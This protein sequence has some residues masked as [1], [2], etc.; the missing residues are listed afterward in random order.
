MQQMIMSFVE[1]VR[2]AVMSGFFVYAVLF[3]MLALTTLGALGNWR[4]IAAYMLGWM[5]AIFAVVLITSSLGGN[6]ASGTGALVQQHDALNP[7]VLIVPAIFGGAAGFGLLYVLIRFG[8]TEGTRSMIIAV[9]T[10]LAGTMVFRMSLAVGE[11]RSVISTGT[12]A[13]AIGALAHIVIRGITIS[14]LTRAQ[15]H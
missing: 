11:V 10:A 4:K 9:V 14:N 2:A 12:I 1:W 5:S 15:T 3:G 7:L 13:F 6:I 8:D